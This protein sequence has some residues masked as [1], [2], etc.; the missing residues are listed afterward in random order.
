MCHSTVKQP[1]SANSVDNSQSTGFHFIELHLPSIGTVLVALI[2]VLLMSCCL[3]K[4]WKGCRRKRELQQQQGQQQQQQ[5]QNL[6]AMESLLT[7]AA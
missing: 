4:V 7:A 2:V 5:Q 6:M 1:I 3:W